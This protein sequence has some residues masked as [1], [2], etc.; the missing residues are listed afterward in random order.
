MIPSPL[1]Y[2][3][4]KY[5]LLPQITP[6]FPKDV[7]T[8]VDLFCGGCNVG[9]NADSRR[10][11]YN[12]INRDLLSIY[13]VFKTLGRECLLDSIYGIIERYG[14]SL[15][16]RYGYSHYGCDSGSG[17]AGYNRDK[18]LKLRA[19]FNERRLKGSSDICQHIMLYVLIVYAFNNQIRFNSDGRFN[20]PVGKRDFNSRME[21]KLL[22]FTD[23]LKAQDCLFN[24]GISGNSTRPRLPPGT[25]CTPTRRTLSPAPHITRRAAGANPRKGTCWRFWTNCTAGTSPLPCPMSCAARGRKTTSLSGGLKAAPAYIPPSLLTT[26]TPIPTIRQRTELPRLRRF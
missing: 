4:G 8:F 5:R 25:L 22:D 21:R 19:D 7:S 12:D 23:R 18:Y 24:C 20:L 3:G 6:L 14:L 16:S 1:N 15:T 9:I 10:V 11:I 13:G 26:A 17:L 2:T